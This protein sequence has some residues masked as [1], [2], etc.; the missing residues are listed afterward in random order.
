M[1]EEIKRRGRPKK[2]TITAIDNHTDLPN[3]TVTDIVKQK[4]KRPKRSENYKVHT[5]P[6]EMSQM[7]R[8]AMGL[9]QMGMQGIDLNNAKAIDKRIDDFLTY[10]IDHEMKPTVESMALAFDTNRMQLWRWKEGADGTH[11]PEASRNA[12]K[13][14]YTLMNQLLSQYMT[15][16]KI[17]PVSAIFLLKNNH[18]YKDQTDVVVTPANPYSE[19]DPV[20]VRDKYLDGIPTEIAGEGHID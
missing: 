1:A 5:E 7:I 14:G 12:I 17:N 10:C 3:E 4:H 19:S 9:R 16:G 8:N 11:L 2:T 15:D 6:G 18:A 13:R 20:D